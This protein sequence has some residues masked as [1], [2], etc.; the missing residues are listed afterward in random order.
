MLPRRE[1]TAFC[2]VCFESAIFVGGHVHLSSGEK[3]LAGW[4]R[5]HSTGDLRIR[6][7]N[8]ER[9]NARVV[10]ED[11]SRLMAKRSSQDQRIFFRDLTRLV[12][13][14]WGSLT[15]NGLFLFDPLV[16]LSNRRFFVYTELVEVVG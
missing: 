3:I 5:E 8:L 10:T 11:I 9:R 14:L 1:M 15:E 2:S 13:P 16:A 12:P 4:C 7:K 6:K